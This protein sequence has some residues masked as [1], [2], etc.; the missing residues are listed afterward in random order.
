MDYT[1]TSYN[2]TADNLWSRLHQLFPMTTTSTDDR[3]R[4]FYRSGMS[5]VLAILWQIVIKRTRSQKVFYQAIKL[6][7]VFQFLQFKNL[8]ANII[9]NSKIDGMKKSGAKRS[10]VLRDDNCDP[11]LCQW[12]SLPLLW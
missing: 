6:F 4:Y 10:G 7:F 12:P 5:T 2:E 11:F 8:V 3:V 1:T 9:L